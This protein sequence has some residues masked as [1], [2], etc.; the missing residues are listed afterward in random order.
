MSAVATVLSVNVGKPRSYERSRGKVTTAIWKTPVSGRVR[1]I[2]VNLE[3]D[4][5]AD[6]VN[7]GGWNKAIYAYAADDLRYWEEQLGHTLG[8]GSMGENLT[9]SGIDP[10]EALIGERWAIGTTLLEVSEP[11]SPCYRLG[12]RHG[13]PTLPRRFIAAQRPGTY[14]RIIQQGDIGAGDRIEVIERPDHTVT[15]RLAFQAWL[16][17]HSL[18]P[19]LRA[20]PQLSDAWKAWI[21]KQNNGP[22]APKRNELIPRESRSN[23]QGAPGDAEA[24][25]PK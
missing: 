23:T 6:R 15:V 9:T 19:R 17:D 12:I 22:R 3:G 25:G 16:I 5:Q 1:T 18:A 11:R 13:D 7:H 10:N 2:G 20:A 14:L 8:P 21:A 4:E 24:P